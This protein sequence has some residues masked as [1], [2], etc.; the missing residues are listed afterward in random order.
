[1]FAEAADAL[2]IQ[3]A[4][5][6]EK[7]YWAVKL[8]AAVSSIRP[9]GYQLVFCGGT[10][11]A[12]AHINTQRM[13]ED[14]DMKMVPDEIGDAMSKA[15]R[16]RARSEVASLIAKRLAQSGHFSLLAA[17]AK[18]NRNRHQEFLIGYPKHHES[19]DA[20]RTHS[21]PS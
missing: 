2:G 4:A 9:A 21:V 13:S 18:Q 8:L 17:P 15:E 19:P 1:M 7:D 14:I 5:F 11:L 3:N 20:L 10:C 16:K 6:V 12:K